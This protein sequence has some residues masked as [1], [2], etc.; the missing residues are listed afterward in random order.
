[1]HS[2]GS[3]AIRPAATTGRAR[4]ARWT[5][6]GEGGASRRIK[7][8][9]KRSARVEEARLG[10][11]CEGSAFRHKRRDGAPR[12]ERARKA[13]I[14]PPGVKG[15]TSASWC[16]IP[17]ARGKPRA[18]VR[19]GSERCCLKI[20]FVIPGAAQCAAES[21]FTRVFNALWRRSAL[22]TRDPGPRTFVFLDPGSRYARPG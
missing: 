19:R 4:G 22:Q 14:T 2:G 20:I 10:G 13:R 16:S 11:R 1:M 3:R 18:R 17:L 5:W 7:G 6:Q 21:A 9:D 12:G 8:R 15:K